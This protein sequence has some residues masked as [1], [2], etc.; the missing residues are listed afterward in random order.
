MQY[1]PKFCS[2]TNVL[3]ES[4]MMIG[5]LGWEKIDLIRALQHLAV[6]VSRGCVSNKQAFVFNGE[7][8]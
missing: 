8:F 1:G 3:S 5:E 2:G 7:S 4:C 6:M